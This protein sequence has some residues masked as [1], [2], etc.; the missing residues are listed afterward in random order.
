MLRERRRRR[1]VPGG[2]LLERGPA[3]LQVHPEL[4]LSN[5]R[6]LSDRSGQNPRQCGPVRQRVPDRVHPEPAPEPAGADADHR[7]DAVQRRQHQDRYTA[8]AYISKMLVPSSS[9]EHRL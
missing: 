4:H 6:S 5:G 2:R 3:Q 8:T 1:G 9:Y 7:L